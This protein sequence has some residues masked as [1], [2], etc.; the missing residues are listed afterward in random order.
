MIESSTYNPWQRTASNCEERLVCTVTAVAVIHRQHPLSVAPPSGWIPGCS[1]CLNTRSRSP[2]RTHIRILHRTHAKRATGLTDVNLR[3][4]LSY[5][6]H[7]RPRWPVTL[8]WGTLWQ[9]LILGY[10][11]YFV[12]FAVRGLYRGACNHRP[13]SLHT[14]RIWSFTFDNICGVNW[15]WKMIRSARRAMLLDSVRAAAGPARCLT[16]ALRLSSE[17]A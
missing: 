14:L 10:R 5:C 15:S 7:Y 11:G 1:A 6:H 3:V 13:P 16:T 9:Y 4:I 17:S 2:A 12:A 8:W